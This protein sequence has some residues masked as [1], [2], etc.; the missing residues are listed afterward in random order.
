MVVYDTIKVGMYPLT[1]VYDHDE[2]VICYVYV[3][4]G[5]SCVKDRE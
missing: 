1:K 4:I 3:S 5:V 2:N